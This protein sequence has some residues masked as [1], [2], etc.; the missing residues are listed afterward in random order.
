MTK[1]KFAIEQNT[2]RGFPELSGPAP[3]RNR[4]EVIRFQLSTGYIPRGFT[5]D[6]ILHAIRVM[7]IE[8]FKTGFPHYVPLAELRILIVRALCE[9][10]TDAAVF[11]DFAKHLT[12][13]TIDSGLRYA[14]RRRAEYPNPDDALLGNE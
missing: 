2:R 12:Q 6:T 5:T 10:E 4:A 1:L 14:V 8:E 9:N 13:A 3:V 7:G 11:V